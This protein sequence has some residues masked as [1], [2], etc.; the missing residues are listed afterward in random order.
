MSRRGY[1]SVDWRGL[2]IKR[3][4]PWERDVTVCIAATCDNDGETKIVICTDKKAS[5][6]LGSSET[7]LKIRDLRHGW[8]CL[9]SGTESDINALAYLYDLQFFDKEKLKYNKID[10]TIKQPLYE[11]K[12]ILADEYVRNRFAMSHEDFLKTGKER[13]PSDI[14]HDAVQ[15]ISAID[16]KAEF[17]V[18]GFIE[19]TPEIYFTE[20]TGKAH[21]ATHF[22]VIGEGEYVASSAL[23]RRGQYNW[24]SLELTLYNVYEAKKLAEAVGSVGTKTNLAVIGKDGEA[25]LLG[26]DIDNQLEALYNKYGPQPVPE[27]LKFDGEFYFKSPD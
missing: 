13:L 26:L 20:S 12:R 25:K 16:L 10:E 18:V 14:F 6:V 1:G 15:R 11:R 7:H 5:N 24:L 23:M 3:P 2:P 27:E 21:A 4:Y 19:D 22:A 9:T 8:R 17:I